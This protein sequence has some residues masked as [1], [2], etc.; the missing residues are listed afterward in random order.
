MSSLQ[1]RTN[2]LS[3]E[4]TSSTSSSSTARSYT[5][6]ASS[7]PSAD[8][9]AEQWPPT[10]RTHVIGKRHAITSL[11]EST[12]KSP[13][14]KMV[15]NFTADWQAVEVFRRGYSDNADDCE[16]TVLV[17]SLERVAIAEWEP[18]LRAIQALC[19]E[20]CREPI[21]AEVLYGTVERYTSDFWQTRPGMG[22][23]IGLQDGS[24]SGTVGGFLELKRDGDIRLV[25]VTC[26]HVVSSG[27]PALG[28][29]DE[30]GGTAVS[31]PAQSDHKRELAI[32]EEN[33]ND[34][35][36][37]KAAKIELTGGFGLERYLAQ[38]AKIVDMWKTKV[39]KG[40][41]FSLRY[42][43]V[44]ATSGLRV[45]SR[46]ASV[47]WGLVLPDSSRVGKNEIPAEASRF[48]VTAGD[49]VPLIDPMDLQLGGRVTKGG[50]TTG[51]R[52]GVINDLRS[53]CHLN[54]GPDEGT[55]EYCV[56]GVDAKFS[57]AGDSGAW[58]LEPLLGVVTG[59]VIGG[60]KGGDWTYISPM[61]E[62]VA[63]IERTLS[64]RVRLPF[65]DE[66]K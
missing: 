15:R 20:V 3:D 42:G 46:G 28:P 12:L 48:E 57:E 41:S 21:E 35:N 65:I 29:Y 62:I 31:Q 7:P 56:K 49:Q 23:S 2:N 59:M 64:G 24:R 13:V 33:I 66:K 1:R 63:D 61:K 22:C 17:T 19:R 50:K 39:A 8:P 36:T 54:G 60:N 18:V 27:V 25:A 44:F 10:L 52:T 14:M 11:W 37:Q 16:A 51:W 5:T 55:S 4:S 40:T 34:I 32:L 45:N 30:E 6:S 38:T 47:D 26:H 58:V 43:R 53:Q 9:G